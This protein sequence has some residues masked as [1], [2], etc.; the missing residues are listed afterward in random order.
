MR[1]P[2]GA[3]KT[4]PMHAVFADGFV[5]AVAQTT[6]GEWAT[7]PGAAGTAQPKATPRGKAKAKAKAG[8]NTKPI[9]DNIF[10]TKFTDTEE[11]VSVFC[12]FNKPTGS[13]VTEKLVCMKRDG[14]FQTVQMNI[15]LFKTPGDP[16]NEMKL[17]ERCWAWVEDKAIQY[18]KGKLTDL[19][20]KNAKKAYLKT[21]G[22]P[23]SKKMRTSG[24]GAADAA[25]AGDG[26]G[27]AAAGSGPTGAVQATAKAAAAADQSGSTGAQETAAAEAAAEPSGLTGAAQA[28]DTATVEPSGSTDA[29]KTVTA[30]AA[31][32]L[33]GSAGAAEATATAESEVPVTPPSKRA[34]VGAAVAAANDDK[35]DNPVG[36]N[37]GVGAQQMVGVDGGAAGPIEQPVVGTDGGQ[38]T[39]IDTTAGTQKKTIEPW[40][41][42]DDE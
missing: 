30:E 23:A 39:P 37:G 10:T 12:R 19:D 32:G 26:A 27:Q 22:E 16:E 9:A 33:G 34:K 42:D 36:A 5:A 6:V 14:H 31:A 18:C 35:A 13:T 38:E 8:A 3:R 17:W 15:N 25:A 40:S 28:R 21:L 1:A 4:D 2:V 41:D 7:A 29:A 24:R 20:I 11:N